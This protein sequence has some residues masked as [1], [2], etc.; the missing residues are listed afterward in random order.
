MLEYNIN[1]RIL[2]SALI[3]QFLYKHLN[4][5]ELDLYIILNRHEDIGLIGPGHG[6]LTRILEFC[7][8]RTVM[9]C[10]HAILHDAFGRFYQDYGKGPGYCYAIPRYLPGSMRKKSSTWS[11]NGIIF[12][13]IIFILIL[14]FNL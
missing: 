2:K 11:Y 12:I 1:P 13:I 4:F 6:F 9:F 8:N 3:Y 14:C 10:T 5:G 7:L